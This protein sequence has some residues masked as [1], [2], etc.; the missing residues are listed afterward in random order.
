MGKG[1]ECVCVCVCVCVLHSDTKLV[2]DMGKGRE[3]ARPTASNVA[4][5]QRKVPRPVELYLP[6]NQK[7]KHQGGRKRQR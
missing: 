2:I 1:R 7:N 4:V 6:I 3:N 5:Q